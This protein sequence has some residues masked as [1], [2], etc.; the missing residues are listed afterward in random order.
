MQPHKFTIC[1]FHLAGKQRS[2][3]FSLLECP[4]WTFKYR[5]H[6]AHTDRAESRGLVP[7]Y[8]AGL[9]DFIKTTSF[10]R[11][12]STPADRLHG[13]ELHVQ[14]DID[15]ARALRFLDFGLVRFLGGLGGALPLIVFD[16]LRG[17]DFKERL[18]EY[19]SRPL[20]DADLDSCLGVLK[21]VPIYITAIDPT[22]CDEPSGNIAEGKVLWTMTEDQF[23]DSSTGDGPD[24]SKA[25]AVI[26]VDHFREAV[27]SMSGP[28][29]EDKAGG[30]GVAVAPTWEL[31]TVVGRGRLLAHE[32][33][34]T[35]RMHHS[36]LHH[37]SSLQFIRNLSGDWCLEVGDFKDKIA[38]P[39]KLAG[40]TTGHTLDSHFPADAGRTLEHSI[41]GG[42]AIFELD[43]DVVVVLRRTDSEPAAGQPDE[44]I[45]KRR[46]GADS[47]AEVYRDPFALRAISR[48]L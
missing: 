24:V 16:E 33:T 6:C 41:T 31:K 2:H 23:T 27:D 20:S 42:L 37:R 14:A 8:R 13:L 29:L 35:V 9:L 26:F 3:V 34:H 39:A 46:L 19:G 10:K 47:I 4:S 32:G 45:R 22:S 43:L 44:Q 30:A 1:P 11:L 38:T 40:Y 7:I 12:I 15:S 48:R 25:I 36:I 5:F 17:E 21:G 18:E 28:D